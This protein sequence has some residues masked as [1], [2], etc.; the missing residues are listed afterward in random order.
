VLSAARDGFNEA[1]ILAKLLPTPRSGPTPTPV[2][3]RSTRAAVF[4]GE[5][6]RRLACKIKTSSDFPDAELQRKADPCA[7]K[8]SEYCQNLDG[9]RHR[10]AKF[11]EWPAE[12]M[13][14]GPRNGDGERTN[15]RTC[16]RPHAVFLHV[17]VRHWDRDRCRK[18][19]HLKRGASAGRLYVGR[20]QADTK[21]YKT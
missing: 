4:L 5:Q 7:H 9:N 14:E 1:K 19:A 15:D 20:D 21:L 18:L 2:S 11:Q 8:C 6:G 10:S 17:C 13:R 3:S 12:G 16:H